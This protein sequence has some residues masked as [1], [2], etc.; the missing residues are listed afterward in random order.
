M[1]ASSPARLWAETLEE[2]SNELVHLNRDTETEF[3]RVG[4][5]VSEFINTVG[6]LSTDLTSLA[7]LISGEHGQQ[8]SD[9]LSGAL[10]LSEQMGQRSDDAN[11]L[12][13]NMKLEAR[14]LKQILSQFNGTVATFHSLGLL[15]RIETAR[16]GDLGAD[17]GNLAEDV[18]LLARNVQT[19]VDTALDTAAELIPQIDTALHDASGLHSS[20]AEH[21]P[22]VISQS[23][24][25]ISTFRQM[26]TSAGDA[27]IRLA[28][29]YGE[30]SESFKRLIT[31][32]QFNDITRQ[33]IEHVITVL[34][35]L[36]TRDTDNH[37]LLERSGAATVLDLQW[38]LMEN[39]T[40][41]F[42]ASVNTVLQS[43]DEIAAH[44]LNMTHE[45]RS[46][47]HV[48][49]SG[50]SSFFR[51]M[52]QGCSA[53]LETLSRCAHADTASIATTENLA[54]T[55]GRM[56][57]SIQEIRIIENQM[58]RI[59]MNA[60]IS[61]DHL[62]SAGEALSALADAIKQ[63]AF[64]SKEG[65]DLLV[66]TLDVLGELAASSSTQTS[67]ALI[68]Q[69]DRD[70]RL[71]DIRSAVRLL[72]S[73]QDSSSRQIS[74]ILTRGDS[75]HQNISATRTSFSV[76]DSFSAVIARSRTKVKAISIEV[77]SLSNSNGTPREI[78]NL[79]E[80]ASH[81]TMNAERDIHAQASGVTFQPPQRQYMNQEPVEPGLEE[82]VVF[83]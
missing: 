72:R 18:R 33:Q 6:L 77:D 51:H 82:D 59:G 14:S 12:L 17:F 80:F 71:E 5:K 66:K 50:H 22:A 30:I 60:R 11:H 78:L 52:E 37:L 79:S 40:T 63:R 21:L 68:D 16:L 55:T 9:A 42:V 56:R 62:G 69:Q 20:L 10:Q 36:T 49:G 29:S 44:V 53:I 75:L 15:T 76:S 41:Q 32:V 1:S 4:A 81:Y 48:S 61:A 73:S 26:Q 47:S 24:E 3:L 46:L 58:L 13:G 2:I 57:S 28:A 19:R 74:Q 27:S 67:S 23:L 70:Q 8:A 83:F 64:E 45:S 54:R 38:S 25:S 35:R 65:S 43:L 34:R 39:A 31:S 7:D